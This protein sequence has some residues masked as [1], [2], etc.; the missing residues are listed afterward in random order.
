MPPVIHV[1]DSGTR[2]RIGWLKVDIESWHI[3]TFL[4]RKCMTSKASY[5]KTKAIG[6][7]LIRYADQPHLQVCY[8]GPI[9]TNKVT[10]SQNCDPLTQ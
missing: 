3:R 7:E 5:S 1:G 6:N 10:V 4:T 2:T 8:V 9:C